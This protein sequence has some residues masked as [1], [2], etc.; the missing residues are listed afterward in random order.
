MSNTNFDPRA[1]TYVE[2]T[3]DTNGAPADGS[4]TNT[5]RARIATPG[6]IALREQNY[7]VT[8]EVTS[9]S[10]VF[11]DTGGKD[12]TA[13]INP[14][15]SGFTERIALTDTVSEQ[16]SLRGSVFFP[17]DV[18]PGNHAVDFS[19][20]T[21]DQITFD[22]VENNGLT[23]GRLQL[24]ARI[25]RNGQPFNGTVRFSI[26]DDLYDNSPLSPPTSGSAPIYFWGTRQ[27]SIDV[28]STDGYASTSVFSDNE[29]TFAAIK[30][31][32]EGSS[33]VGYQLVAF[34]TQTGLDWRIVAS[35][36]SPTPANGM[37][38]C[39]VTA[40]V[41]RGGT[42]YQSSTGNAYVAVYGL[43][44]DH[45]S[46]RYEAVPWPNLG[47]TIIATNTKPEQVQLLIQFSEQVG[48]HVA[49]L[50]YIL[51]FY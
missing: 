42:P 26:T 27:K 35:P 41:Y 39:V 1:T 4:S 29:N 43:R 28:T 13:F 50:P 49:W 48:R 20:V 45:A 37:S 17:L 11:L 51:N 47:T 3:S 19:A 32:I 31:Q 46:I 6:G 25:L 16:V 36:S 23:V 40:T 24:R 9:G 5:V 22:P 21:R 10:A 8:L 34:P 15:D 2:I 7:P 18:Q 14:L 12:I 44:S 30:A 33:S 38:Q